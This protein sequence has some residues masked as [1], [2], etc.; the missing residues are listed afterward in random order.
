MLYCN[1]FSV[2]AVNI[3][4]VNRVVKLDEI[5]TV[6]FP[7]QQNSLAYHISHAAKVAL[8]PDPYIVA[9]ANEALI[10]TH[11]DG[12]K[13]RLLTAF[14]ILFASSNGAHIQQ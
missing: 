9:Y 5:F 4:I 1:V 13:A 6:S 14:I 10:N 2:T 11:T 7:L 12:A 8:V 3:P